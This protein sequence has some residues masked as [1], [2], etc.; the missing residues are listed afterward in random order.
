MTNCHMTIPHA[1]HPFD[2]EDRM[3]LRESC[4]GI[5][6]GGVRTVAD[7]TSDHIGW[8]I[9]VGRERG[10]SDFN[11]GRTFVLKKLRTWTYEGRTTVG[12]VDPTEAGGQWVGTEYHYD[13]DT[14]CMLLR[15]VTAP[16]KRRAKS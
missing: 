14:S 8:E 9:R 12:L 16:A 1:P 7:L 15:P 3:P 11:M 2:S 13:P 5:P 4:Q 6:D 10:A